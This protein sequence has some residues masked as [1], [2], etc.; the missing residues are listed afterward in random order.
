MRRY[1]LALLGLL[2]MWLPAQNIARI[3]STDDSAFQ[4]LHRI[5]YDSK[6]LQIEGQD[7]FIYSGAFHYYRCPK[8]LW[9]DR[10]LKIKE[11]GFNSVETYVPWN[12]HER[13]MPSSPNDCSNIDLSEL[14]EWMEM[15][16]DFGF[17]IIIRPGPYI[18]SEWDGGGFPQWLASKRP[19]TPKHKEMWL[20]TDDP[21]FLKWNKHWYAA[22][23]KMVAPHQIT[24]KKTGS[25]GVIMFQVE[26]E[27]ERLKLP[28]DMKREYLEELVTYARDGGIEVPIFTCWTTQS[29]NVQEGPLRGVFDFVNQYPQWDIKRS[30]ERF[31]ARQKKDQPNA[32]LMTG[33]LQGGWYSEVGGILSKDQDG[34]NAVQTQNLTLYT[35]QLGYSLINYYM[36][37]GGTNFDDWASRETT[38]TY[39]FAAAI[40]ENGGVNEKYRRM[41]GIGSML[42]EHGT[43][44][45]RSDLEKTEVFTTDSTVEVQ[46]R[47]SLDGS[48]YYFIRTEDR[49]RNHSGTI[50]VKEEN[51]NQIAFSYDLEPFGSKVFYLPAGA[52]DSKK[53][54]WYP[55]LPAPMPRPAY[56]PKE[57]KPTE[58]FKSADLIS[59][60]WRT[61]KSNT[62]IDTYE[63]YDRHFVY[64]QV[65][66]PSGK[67]FVI[68]RIGN[69]LINKSKQDVVVA[70][71]NGKLLEPI[72]ENKESITFRMPSNAKKALLLF[73]NR[74]LHHHTNLLVEQHWFNGIKSVLVDGKAIPIQFV[75]DER[76]K[77]I[78]YSSPDYITDDRWIKT[79][80]DEGKELSSESLLTWYRFSFELPE[81]NADVW[82][83][84][85]L[86]MI[87]KGNGFI[88]LNGYCIGR[89]WE[90]G[91]QTNYY[92]PECWLKF[93]KGKNNI[94]TMSLRSTKNG[95]YFE[96][97]S[98]QPAYDAAEFRP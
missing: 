64:Y 74:G 4:H 59:S 90:E 52:M 82:F 6:C 91:S 1:I 79:S 85:H 7:I 8:E 27:Y 23:T 78:E 75:S 94:I 43:R 3:S 81:E 68:N 58:I 96:D 54:R 41:C 31:T 50:Q 62:S 36:L 97:V 93:G 35:I 86:K 49:T 51:G 30:M 25:S 80:I 24:R 88:Y 26:N 63:V 9:A 33:E 15:A 5:R 2:P 37:C 45:I 19:D 28:D 42:K 20:Q 55:D 13:K 73:E 12:Y 83:P 46:M 17:Y 98:V 92:L 60:K 84:W 14:K 39:D 29:R 66:V 16:E 87:A 11:A 72:S 44:L 89:Y 56:L 70:L 22:V 76:S 53:G 77:G 21:E 34:V 38:T 69:Q 32:P 61:L 48:R 95:A 65:N 47:R 57:V 18:C 67:D 10:F 40:Q 71:V